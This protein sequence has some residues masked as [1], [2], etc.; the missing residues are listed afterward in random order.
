MVTQ[1]LHQLDAFHMKHEHKARSGSLV[2]RV[3]KGGYDR[4]DFDVLILDWHNDMQKFCWYSSPLADSCCL[5][6]S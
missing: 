4:L 2:F 1:W 5:H 6:W 3:E